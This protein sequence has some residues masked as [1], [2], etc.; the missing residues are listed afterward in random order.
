MGIDL[1]VCKLIGVLMSVM[2]CA[3]ASAP[4]QKGVPA[5]QDD[6]TFLPPH[7]LGMVSPSSKAAASPSK[8]A[9]Q[10]A[11]PAAP[12]SRAAEK[13][14]QQSSPA[15]HM[16][17]QPAAEGK[18]QELAKPPVSASAKSAMQPSGG[19]T[20][21]APA[22]I[23]R[24]NRVPPAQKVAPKPH[25]APKQ[26]SGTSAAAMAAKLAG[27]NETMREIRVTLGVE[28]TP[29]AR[30]PA[31][32]ASQKAGGAG[33]VCAR[34]PATGTPPQAAP[35]PGVSAAVAKH[36]A[37]NA[38][39]A[40]T[41]PAEQRPSAAPLAK[42]V[43]AFQAPATRPAQDIVGSRP[44][45]QAAANQPARASQALAAP[46]KPPV[47]SAPA[48]SPQPPMHQALPAKMPPGISAPAISAAPPALQPVASAPVSAEAV[49][50]ASSFLDNLAGASASP[51]GGSWSAPLFLGAAPIRGGLPF[52]PGMAA[53][54]GLPGSSGPLPAA[55]Q[56]LSAHLRQ[57]K[58]ATM[59]ASPDVSLETLLQRLSDM[60]GNLPASASGR[61]QQKASAQ[62]AAAPK[63]A[64]LSASM[65]RQPVSRSASPVSGLPL[66]K[67]GPAPL[68][69]GQAAGAAGQPKSGL[70]KQSRPEAA[71][72]K[73]EAITKLQSQIAEMQRVIEAKEQEAKRKAA[74]KA[75]AE[76]QRVIE[77]SS[78]AAP[79]K[80]QPAS[81]P[82]APSA[83]AA[84]KPQAAAP[85]G[86]ISAPAQS[87][88][89]FAGKAAE[90]GPH[91]PPHAPKL[92][93][94]GRRAASATPKPA[95]PAVHVQSAQREQSPAGGKT[96]GTASVQPTPVPQQSVPQTQ[97]PPSIAAP[98][99]STPALAGAPPK[100]ATAAPVSTP[101]AAGV[102]EAPKAALKQPVLTP[103]V[104]ATA[105][106]QPASITKEAAQVAPSAV[107][108]PTSQLEAL[109]SSTRSEAPGKH[110]PAK[111][112]LMAEKDR[113][114]AQAAVPTAATSAAQSKASAM[115]Q[116]PAVNGLALDAAAPAKP[117]PAADTIAEKQHSKLAQAPQAAAQPPAKQPVPASSSA[118]EKPA[119]IAAPPVQQPPAGCATQAAKGAVLTA[120]AA[121]QGD[122]PAAEHT[123]APSG[124]DKHA[125]LPAVQRD[126]SQS[127]DAFISSDTPAYTMLTLTPLGTGS[128]WP[129]SP[130]KPAKP[131]PTSSQCI[132]V[133]QPT[134]ASG[135]LHVTSSA[136]LGKAASGAA[137]SPA[138]QPAGQAGRM[139]SPDAF[140]PRAKTP[141]S[142]QRPARGRLIT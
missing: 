85:A 75:A 142:E 108:A 89:S 104:L 43:P 114:P 14:P 121:K 130:Q 105:P 116:G 66:K 111:S 136:E 42:S 16:V 11:P 80:S 36:K 19:A 81:A 127:A 20:V 28:E 128:A 2:L 49:A 52:P 40:S 58:E 46:A 109:A 103:K 134:A 65:L 131:T 87:L 23:I 78:K 25:S 67:G 86:S 60:E 123:P 33:A 62:G 140:T 18:P 32:N 9:P 64:S 129:V 41:A 82:A 24:E 29:A 59:R 50:M 113:L 31:G 15:G 13:A 99:P 56:P 138:G 4:E 77:Q 74:A 22:N 94:A 95:S 45:V 6:N 69:Q 34:P 63:P 101:P 27:I 84:Q 12:A 53:L 119:P 57:S 1:S 8:A 68:R 96:G 135:S 73:P 118:S 102:Q 117:A 132:A 35:A 44:S 38:A 92:P 51:S 93:G 83:P 137:L 3:G 17:R 126:V 88:A 107:Q 110:Q 70:A 48:L 125:P 98:L 5:S 91:K 76:G 141:T 106:A 10:Q 61:P 30:P 100:P 139:R 21:R 55:G 72:G 133:S 90:L 47:T 71:G 115:G 7:L 120:T 26:Q 112:V 124:P 37:S 122:K 97:A 54:L 39:A 79:A